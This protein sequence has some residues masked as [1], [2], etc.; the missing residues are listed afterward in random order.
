MPVA[1]QLLGADGGRGCSDHP[2][3]LVC[4]LLFGFGLWDVVLD[5]GKE[6]RLNGKDHPFY[7]SIT[8]QTLIST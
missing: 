7:S 2:L 4:S 3:V 1:W 6:L 5:V 8:L